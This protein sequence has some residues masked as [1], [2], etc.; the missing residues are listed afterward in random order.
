[1]GHCNL[2]GR[3]NC[4][5]EIFDIFVPDFITEYPRIQ[6]YTFVAE[7]LLLALQ[8]MIIDKVFLV[9][10]AVMKMSCVHALHHILH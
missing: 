5:F 4:P 9:F 10:D 2:V 1:M 7:G 8:F 3:Y 6:K